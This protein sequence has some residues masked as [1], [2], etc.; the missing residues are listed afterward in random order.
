VSRI[1][2]SERGW[3]TEVSRR[4]VSQPSEERETSVNHPRLT[5]TKSSQSPTTNTNTTT[6]NRKAPWQN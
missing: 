1:S 5:Q 6:R 4:R 3:F 2:R